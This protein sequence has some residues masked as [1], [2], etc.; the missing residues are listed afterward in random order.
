MGLCHRCE[1]RVK[2]IEGGHGPRSECNDLEL[3]MG[4]CY[5]YEPVKPVVLKYPDY[6]D[7]EYGKMNK[8]RPVSGGLFGARM[9]F[10]SIA[11]CNVELRESDGLYT[12]FV[13]P[14]E[15]DNGE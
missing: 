6:G 3:S 8:Q 7:S 10:D 13:V 4:S 15:K 14:K 5:C 11:D 1:K 12:L 9:S 2:V